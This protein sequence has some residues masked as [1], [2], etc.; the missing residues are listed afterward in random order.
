MP[1]SIV[2]GVDESASAKR[3]AADVNASMIVVG[4]TSAGGIVR[5]DLGSRSA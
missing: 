1:G 2:C 3:A 5:C 4:V